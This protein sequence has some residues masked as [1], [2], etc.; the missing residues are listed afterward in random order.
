ML[1]RDKYCYNCGKLVIDTFSSLIKKTNIKDTIPNIKNYNEPQQSTTGPS[2]TES[3]I[4]E[5]HEENISSKTESEIL[6]LPYSWTVNDIE[7]TILGLGRVEDYERNNPMSN[8]KQYEVLI[9]F[10][11]LL[12]TSNKIKG[13]SF[14]FDTLKLR[15]D[16]GNTWDLKSNVENLTLTGTIDPEEEF[17]RNDSVFEI[18]GKELPECLLA[19]IFGKKYLFAIKLMSNRKREE[20]TENYQSRRSY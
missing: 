19:E 15:T 12:K 5:K 7:I 6:N 14:G 16:V 2:S 17:I 18:R 8:K 20:E 1:S 10:R 11:N 13:N 3:D 9:K 4:K